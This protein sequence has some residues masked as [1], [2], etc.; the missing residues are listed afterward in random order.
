M[1]ATPSPYTMEEQPTSPGRAFLARA[2]AHWCAVEWGFSD[3]EV[4]AALDGSPEADPE[5]RRK[6]ESGARLIGEVIAAGRMRTWARPVGGGVPERMTAD[7]W[8]LDDFRHRMSTSAVALGRP[9][10]VEAPR[11]HW[12]FVEL[13]DFNQLVEESIGVARP[14][15]KTQQHQHGSPAEDIGSEPGRAK[16]ERLL[17]LPE[18]TSRTGLSRSTIYDR[19]ASGRFPA[20]VPMAGNITVWRESEIEEWLASPR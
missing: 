18:V 10:D 11:S 4:A 9:F 8:E 5:V 3:A 12:I 19:M 16:P 14:R 7:L 13:E 17:R 6:V 2:F 1:T 20:K 15:G